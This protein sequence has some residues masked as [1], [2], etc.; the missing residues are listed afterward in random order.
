MLVPRLVHKRLHPE[1]HRIVEVMTI[2][3][4]QVFKLET[5]SLEFE[6][7]IANSPPTPD[8]VL[9]KRGQEV[10]ISPEPWS[11]Y[12]RWHSGPLDRRD[13][14]LHRI[15]CTQNARGYCRQHRRSPRFLYDECFSG[16]SRGLQA[17]R[18]LDEE[19]KAEY[20]VYLAGFPSQGGLSVK[21]GVTRR[22]RLL[23]RISEQPHIAATVVAVLDSAYRARRLELE[24]YKR[25]LARQAT[26]KSGILRGLR[27]LET[28]VTLASAAEKA[29]T[30]AGTGWDGR[31]F[32]VS[33]PADLREPG[34]P[35]TGSRV[36]LY[37]Y[38]GGLLGVLSSGRLLWFRATDLMHRSSLLL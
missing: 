19:L 27:R 15:Y 37:S 13:D 36:V 9:I 11:E 6:G 22:F 20:A 10:S 16:G 17:C 2:S 14:P 3:G 8:A 12:C 25:G 34:R 38:W 5:Y 24:I 7:V 4:S 26:R 28:I 30:L 23:D 21:V 18:A 1:G 35:P 33:P 32:S 31:L 29:S